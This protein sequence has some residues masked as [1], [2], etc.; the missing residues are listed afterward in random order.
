MKVLL[1]VDIDENHLLLESN[2][3]YDRMKGR[4]CEL[5]PIP[6][7]F[8]IDIEDDYAEGWNACIKEILNDR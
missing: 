5:K 2:D 7:E 3:L 1:V 4:K 8:G 6:T